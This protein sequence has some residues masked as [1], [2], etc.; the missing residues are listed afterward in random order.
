MQPCE[1]PRDP[2]YPFVQPPNQNAFLLFFYLWDLE[3]FIPSAE[4][5]REDGFSF[6]SGQYTLAGYSRISDRQTN[7]ISKMALFVGQGQNTPQ[8][9][10]TVGGRGGALLMAFARLLDIIRY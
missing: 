10:A 2:N 6:I 4:G 5:L 1:R 3:S 8:L 9:L 7:S